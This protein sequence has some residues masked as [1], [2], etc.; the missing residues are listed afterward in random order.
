MPEAPVNVSAAVSESS[1]ARTP[2][3][4]IVG[5]CAVIKVVV[6]RNWAMV[7]AEHLGLEE[8]DLLLALLECGTSD[9]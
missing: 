4:H 5:R 7:A 1:A 3:G 8:E 9:G 2:A 6:R